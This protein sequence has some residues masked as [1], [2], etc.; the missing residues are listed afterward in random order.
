MARGSDFL[1]SRGM[2]AAVP[3]RLCAG[4]ESPGEDKSQPRHC[5]TGDRG[6]CRPSATFK[7]SEASWFALG[8]QQEKTDIAASAQEA[9]RASRTKSCPG[10]QMG[11]PVSLNRT[12]LSPHEIRRRRAREPSPW[13]NGAMARYHRAFDDQRS[14]RQPTRN[15]T[16]RAFNLVADGSRSDA[17]PTA[18]PCPS[19][20]GAENAKRADA[21][22]ATIIAPATPMACRQISAGTAM[23]ESP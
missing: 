13:S 8:R 9:T 12:T 21:A 17:E 2:G 10:V 11:D 7:P 3:A 16:G 4:E 20:D 18:A 23:D 1:A 5:G 15:R 6:P 14:A 22:A 19:P